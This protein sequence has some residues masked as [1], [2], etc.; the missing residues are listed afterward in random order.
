[1]SD[2]K[3][4]PWFPANVKPA[5]E[6][7]YERRPRCFERGN[8]PRWLALFRAGEW[9]ACT[10]F[11]VDAAAEIDR[12]EYEEERGLPWRGLSEDKSKE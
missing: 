8:V 11:G 2:I 12:V 6:G 7:V 1:M 5:R 4:T 10:S 3:L 9:H